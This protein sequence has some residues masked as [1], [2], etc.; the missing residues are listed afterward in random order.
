[1][2]DASRHRLLSDTTLGALVGAIGY[3]AAQMAAS[4]IVS[5]A[6]R[7]IVGKAH[8]ATGVIHSQSV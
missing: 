8:P 4:P 2:F 7:S 6:E 3:A 1:V 5:R